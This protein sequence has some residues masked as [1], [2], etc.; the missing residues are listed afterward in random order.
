[1]VQT[2]VKMV[3][4]VIFYYLHLVAVCITHFRKISINPI[5]FTD[6]TVF[7]E[8]KDILF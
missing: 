2:N 8:V 5:K 4:R 1:M 6:V 7:E 3:V